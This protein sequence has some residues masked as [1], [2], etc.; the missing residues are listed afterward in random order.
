[1]RDF[2]DGQEQVLVRRGTKDVGDGPE[3]P[4]PEGR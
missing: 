1:M 2:V 4:G 3:L